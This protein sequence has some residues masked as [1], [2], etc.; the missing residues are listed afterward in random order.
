MTGL[1]KINDIDIYEVYG[2]AILKG[3][4]NDI[5]SPPTPRKRLEYEYTDRDGTAVDTT[6]GLTFEAKRYKLK[7][8]IYANSAAQFWTRYNAFI[9]LI[10]QPGSF[11]LSISDI[12][13]TVT[14]LYEGAKVTNKITR[15]KGSDRIAVEIELSIFEPLQPTNSIANPDL[16]MVSGDNVN[17]VDNP[18]Q[19]LRVIDDALYLTIESGTISSG[20]LAA[21]VDGKYT[22]VEQVENLFVNQDNKLYLNTEI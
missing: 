16:V 21:C 9:A 4:Y 12:D 14:V 20:Q 6:T 22:Q 11:N 13:K 15:I 1:W 10:A 19:V 17:V 18:S 7:C 3:S 5:M 2:V 8:A